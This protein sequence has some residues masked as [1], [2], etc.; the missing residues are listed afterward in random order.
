MIELLALTK[1]LLATL[2]GF[3]NSLTES[4]ANKFSKEM[5]MSYRL[6][7]SFRRSKLVPPQICNCSDILSK[8]PPKDISRIL[9]LA[10]KL[11]KENA[12]A[13]A[14]KTEPGQQPQPNLPVLSEDLFSVLSPNIKEIYD[15]YIRFA[16]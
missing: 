6:L 3:W 11:L 1:S 14:S 2:I 13:L 15:V 12:Q 9:H 10:W 7:D 4:N 8:I 16:T 5:D